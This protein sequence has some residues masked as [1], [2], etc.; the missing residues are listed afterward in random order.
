MRSVP[1]S[2]KEPAQMK[3]ITWEIPKGR[4]GKF[5][6]VPVIHRCREDF[7]CKLP[8][9]QGT[10]RHGKRNGQKAVFGGHVAVASVP[11]GE[12]PAF[13]ANLFAAGEM[14]IDALLPL[15]SLESNTKLEPRDPFSEA[16]AASSG[17][18]PG[19][20]GTML[21]SVGTATRRGR[22]HLRSCGVG[23]VYGYHKL[24]RSKALCVGRLHATQEA[25]GRSKALQKQFCAAPEYRHWQPRSSLVP[26]DLT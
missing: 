6:L 11:V 4:E 23:V 10:A 12:S 16:T 13:K 15:H 25:H 3:G 17:S 21:K 18:V 19:K 22:C 9:S 26:R 2:G 5:N 8:V 20:H 7:F 1:V 14:F 24:V